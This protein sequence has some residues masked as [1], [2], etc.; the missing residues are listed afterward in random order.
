MCIVYNDARYDISAEIYPTHNIIMRGMASWYSEFSPG[1]RS[2]T[3]NMEYFN[4]D[5]MTCAMWDVPFGTILKVTN[6]EN[7]KHIYV[8]VN[9]RGPARRLVMQGRIVDLSMGSFESIADL[10]R[11][12]IRVEVEIVYIPSSKIQERT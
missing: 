6:L 1:I 9:D 7:K 11:G 12:L 8:R 2:T 4:H 10:D 3:A 5:K